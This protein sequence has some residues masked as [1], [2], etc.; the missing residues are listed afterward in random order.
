MD[1]VASVG[2]IYAATPQKTARGVAWSFRVLSFP[3]PSPL[4]PAHI[5]QTGSDCLSW[6][7]PCC[8][9]SLQ[10]HTHTPR[11]PPPRNSSH[12]PRPTHLPTLALQSA[13]SQPL[14]ALPLPQL[15]PRASP[16]APSHPTAAARRVSL[17]SSRRPRSDLAQLVKR[18]WADS[19]S[20]LAWVRSAPHA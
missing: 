2:D 14:P 12:L 17:C 3:L 4:L 10:P 15:P 16:R 13:S 1:A 7:A 5:A 18:E 20:C 6:H 11:P 8:A 19:S 9:W